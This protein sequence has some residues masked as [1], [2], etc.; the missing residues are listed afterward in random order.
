MK[1]PDF[2]RRDAA[3]VSRVLDFGRSSGSVLSMSG[4]RSQGKPLI[5]RGLTILV[6][7]IPPWRSSFW[8]VICCLGV[9]TMVASNS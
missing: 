4:E 9:N 6:K 2:G 3:H 7:R 8:G 1:F 5:A